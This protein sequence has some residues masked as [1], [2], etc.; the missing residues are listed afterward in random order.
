VLTSR[1]FS[2]TCA[3]VGTAGGPGCL[4]HSSNEFLRNLQTK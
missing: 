4:L 2:L 1:S 3:E